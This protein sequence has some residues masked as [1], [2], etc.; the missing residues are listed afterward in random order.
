MSLND[1]GPYPGGG[2]STI[3]TP[4]KDEAELVAPAPTTVE[5]PIA[6]SSADGEDDVEAS[7]PSSVIVVNGSSYTVTVG[8]VSLH[9]HA[10]VVVTTETIVPFAVESD[11]P[12][13][14][15]AAA[16]SLLPTLVDNE[17]VTVIV[18]TDASVVVVAAASLLMVLVD[19][20]LPDQVVQSET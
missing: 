11:A 14:A 2:G 20:A 1:G 6:E 8:L 4:E 15:V 19:D 16:V 13:E 18:M 9:D 5:L 12:D 17:G 7:D 10:A 3:V